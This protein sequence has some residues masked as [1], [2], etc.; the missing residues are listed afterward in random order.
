M[1]LDEYNEQRERINI[2]ERVLLYTINFDLV[3]THPYVYIIDKAKAIQAEKDVAQFAWNFC[4]DSL[5]TR[6]CLQYSPDNI[7]AACVYLAFRGLKTGKTGKTKLLSNWEKLLG[8]DKMTCYAIC[9]EVSRVSNAIEEIDLDYFEK[10][11]S[12]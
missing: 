2:C 5:S 4:N 1:T 9:H 12:K 11:I 7:A 8:I 3:V 6:L 10:D